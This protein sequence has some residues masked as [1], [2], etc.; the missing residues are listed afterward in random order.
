MSRTIISTLV[1]IAAL[2]SVIVATSA[3]AR[4]HRQTGYD[5]PAWA[6]Q[7]DVY[8]PY[9]GPESHGAES[10]WPEGRESYHGANG[11]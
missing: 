1:G 7:T 8:S 5:A 3:S 4:E 11:G 10:A 2:G 9:Q 6:E